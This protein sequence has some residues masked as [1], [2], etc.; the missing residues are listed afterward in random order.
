MSQSHVTSTWYIILTPSKST[1]YQVQ[2]TSRLKLGFVSP[3]HTSNLTSFWFSS[4]KNFKKS[5]V[6]LS[7][8]SLQR[9]SQLYHVRVSI[10]LH[11]LDCITSL[12]GYRFG[13]NKTC[14]ATPLFSDYTKTEM[15]A[16]TCMCVIDFVSPISLLQDS[17]LEL[18]W[19]CSIIIFFFLYYYNFKF[20]WYFVWK[21]KSYA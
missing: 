17:I 15:W 1:G 10:E 12:K 18:F 8:N 6:Q 19:Q 2:S 16:V 4:I 5:M 21:W 9:V 3:S 20:E 13:Q 11:F 14:Q 7:S